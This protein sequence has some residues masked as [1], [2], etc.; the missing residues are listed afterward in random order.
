MVG[1][2]GFEPPTPRSRTDLRSAELFNEL[3]DHAPG[4]QA[5]YSRVLLNPARLPSPTVGT[6]A[7]IERRL[8]GSNRGP[9]TSGTCSCGVALHDAGRRAPRR[10][11]RNSA[12][13]QFIAVSGFVSGRADRLELLIVKQ[14]QQRR[15]PDGYSSRSASTGA[16][17]D[18][19]SAGSSDAASTVARRMAAPNSSVRGSPG[20]M[21]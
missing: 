14:P 10:R 7:L 4:I 19:R 8:A 12:T 3:A 5:A 15:N 21:P 2:S 17:L 13:R 18:A 20:A 6:R 11:R 1:A 9:A 16:T